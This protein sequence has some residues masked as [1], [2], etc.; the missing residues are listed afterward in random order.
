M[1]KLRVFVLLTKSVNLVARRGPRHDTSRRQYI[2]V[3]PIQTQV[4][5]CQDFPQDLHYE[6]RSGQSSQPRRGH[7]SHHTLSVRQL[8]AAP[9]CGIPPAPYTPL[10]ARSMHAPCTL[11]VYPCHCIYV[12]P[13]H[14]IP[15]HQAIWHFYCSANVRSRQCPRY[16]P[17]VHSL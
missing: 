9:H 5:T 2:H 11:H 15:Y 1:H 10:H 4:N 7:A 12:Y 6:C 3:I 17:G 16:A 13:C 8:H 14:C